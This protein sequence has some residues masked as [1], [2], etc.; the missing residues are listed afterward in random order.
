MAGNT[1]DLLL[2]F[3]V[4]HFHMGTRF[5][6]V[7][8]EKDTHQQLPTVFSWIKTTLYQKTDWF[9]TEIGSKFHHDIIV[10]RSLL[11]VS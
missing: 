11:D 8:R 10:N 4:F 3:K 1:N 2:F 7:F 6:F 5:E 9:I